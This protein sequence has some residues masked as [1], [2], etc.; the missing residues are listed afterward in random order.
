MTSNGPLIDRMPQTEMALAAQ[1]AVDRLRSLGVAVA[2]HRLIEAR[3]L[4]EESPDFW[5]LTFKLRRLVP[6]SPGTEVGKGGETFVEV[7]LTT[8]IA[9]LVGT[10]E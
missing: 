1:L 4:L 5:Q 8:R 10:G 3:N 2:D 9:R 6:A 7:D